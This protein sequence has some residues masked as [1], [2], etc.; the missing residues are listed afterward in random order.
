[1]SAVEVM[2]SVDIVALRLAPD[3]QGLQ[4]LLHRR[5]REPHRGQWALPGVIVN[6]STPDNSLD[7]AAERALQEKAQVRPRYME[8]VGTEGN[9][10]RDPRGWSLSTYYLALLDSAEATWKSFYLFLDS[11]IACALMVWF[12]FCMLILL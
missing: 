5:D 11:D 1:M 8:Q 10:F 4:V 3:L 6:G 7:A 12:S 2:A 9:A